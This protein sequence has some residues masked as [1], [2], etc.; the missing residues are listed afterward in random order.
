MKFALLLLY[1]LLQN[2]CPVLGQDVGFT[3]LKIGYAE[4]EAYYDH[5]RSLHRVEDSLKQPRLPPQVRVSLLAH[6]VMLANAEP[7]LKANYALAV[8]KAQQ[9]AAASSGEL[10]FGYMGASFDAYI[11]DAAGVQL[12][13]Q[14]ASGTPYRSVARLKQELTATRMITNGGMYL[15]NNVPQGLFID[16]GRELRPLDT[17]RSAYGNFYMQPNGVFYIDAQGAHVAATT[18]FLARFPAGSRSGI[19]YA[20]QS[21]PMLVAGGQL[22]PQFIYK[23][24]NLHIRSGVGILPDGRVTFVISRQPV[25]FFALAAVFRDVFGC[26]DALYLDGAISLMYLPHRRPADQAGDFG[27][28]IS[29]VDK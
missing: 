8:A 5:A 26:A 16:R 28:M 11:A 29:V 24:A 18:A 17:T 2:A 4:I 15:K 25:S 10:T 19:R 13:W 9:A 3:T 6:R 14:D 1:L 27:V 22:H 23:S 7:K 21:G 20:T 12:H